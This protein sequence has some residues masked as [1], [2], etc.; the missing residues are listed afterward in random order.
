MN[1]T[2]QATF[3]RRA[4][5][6][7]LAS[8]VVL[9]GAGFGVNAYAA[10]TT[11]A[12]TATVLVPIAIAKTADLVFGSFAH[13]TG[14]SVTVSTSGA[15]ATTGPILSAITATPSAAKFDV[16]GDGVST[17]SISFA[18]TSTEL[19][20][21]ATPLD[22]MAFAPASDLTAGN[23]TA[24]NVST[25]T[26]SSGAQSIYVGGVLTVSATQVAHDDY[27]GSIAV[28]VEYN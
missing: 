7:A 16:T 22:T 11:A 2:K 28:A 6:A 18:G 9:G 8:A 17:Y 25:G 15:R 3:G 20:S 23:A 10:G 19:A 27:T 5:K 13:G 12:A 1:N 21:T 24:G 4:L 26:L 14:G